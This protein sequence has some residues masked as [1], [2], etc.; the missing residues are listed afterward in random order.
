M[1][2]NVLGLAIDVGSENSAQS[3]SDQSFWKSIRVVDVRA[4]GS[5]ISAPKC[6]FFHNFDRPDWSFGP[7]YPHEWPP[8]VRGI[9]GP[10]TSSLGCFFLLE[11]CSTKITVSSSRITKIIIFRPK[12]GKE[13]PKQFPEPPSVVF[14]TTRGDPKA[15]WKS[16]P[17]NLYFRFFSNRQRARSL[18]THPH[19]RVTMIMEGL[20][21]SHSAP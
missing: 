4:F 2:H 19:K 10:K 12:V 11:D 18:R 7:G 17:Y 16:Q 5:W 21:V 9:S 8:D 3:F 6:L 13:L 14:C 1:V 20:P 15:S